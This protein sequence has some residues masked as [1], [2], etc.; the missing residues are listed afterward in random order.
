MVKSFFSVIFMFPSRELFKYQLMSSVRL[1]KA[2]HSP[3]S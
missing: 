1:G 2:E 3:S